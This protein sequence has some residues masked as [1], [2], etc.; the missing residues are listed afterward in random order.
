MKRA[1]DTAI[2]TGAA[3]VVVASVFV[4]WMWSELKEA[5]T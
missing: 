4:P 1:L 2:L 3:V 5:L